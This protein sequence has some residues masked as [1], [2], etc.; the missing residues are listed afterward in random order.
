MSPVESC[1][2]PQPHLGGTLLLASRSSVAEMPS[3]P[4]RIARRCDQRFTDPNKVSHDTD[5]SNYHTQ[6]PGAETLRAN[7]QLYPIITIFFRSAIHK[8]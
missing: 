1:G 4:L 6:T 8:P 5:A 7:S 3:N 2:N